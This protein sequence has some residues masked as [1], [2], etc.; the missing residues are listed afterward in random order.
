MSGAG[1]K[2]IPERADKIKLHMPGVW[3][4]VCE[5]ARGHQALPEQITGCKSHL[6]K[7]GKSHQRNS[8]RLR[9]G[10]LK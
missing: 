5:H 7:I 3:L 8:I 1:V 9:K 2:L 6:N 10:E 4:L